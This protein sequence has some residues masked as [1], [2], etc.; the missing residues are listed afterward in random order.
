MWDKVE[1]SSFFLVI[2]VGEIKYWCQIRWDQDIYI[3]IYIYWDLGYC[4]KQK[5]RSGTFRKY[6]FKTRAFWVFSFFFFLKVQFS[7]FEQWTQENSRIN[8]QWL[9]ILFYHIKFTTQVSTCIISIRW[10][11]LILLQCYQIQR[12][13]TCI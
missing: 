1:H 13:W 7:L 9:D 2:H 11:H 12:N 6:Y 3:Y 8:R 5:I 4:E 10:A